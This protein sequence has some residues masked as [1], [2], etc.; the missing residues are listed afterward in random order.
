LPTA[1]D[2]APT[3]PSGAIL[4]DRDRRRVLRA[5]LGGIFATTFTITILGVSLR[6][7]ADDLGT[8]VAT[9]AWVM[10]GPMLAQALSLPVLG[11]MGDL[12]GHRRVYLIGFGVSALAAAATAFAWDA[13][14]LIGFRCLGQLAGTATMPASTALLFHAYP[15]R[16]RVRAMSYVSLVSAGAP[17][18]GLAIGGVLVD[19]IGWR[20]IFAIQ[21]VLGVAALLYAAMVLEESEH[22]GA[23]KLD[24][25]GA[26]TLAIAAFALTFAINRSP[27]WG[28]GHP[29]V[30]LAMAAIP[31]ALL[32]F[33]RIERKAESPLLPL[34]FFRERNFVS[35]LVVNF[36]M[37]FAYMGG[38]IISPLLLI[39]VFGFNATTTSLFVVCR[40]IAFA[41]A[42][43]VSGHIAMRF[44]EQRTAFIGCGLITASMIA[45]CFTAMLVD[46]STAA[47]LGALAF[48]L[49]VAGVGF[50]FIQPSIQA[51]VGNAVASTHFGIASSA[52]GM[53]GSVGAVAGIS[54]L[55]ALCADATGPMPYLH[56][57]ALATISSAIALAAAMMMKTR[58]V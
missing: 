49:V 24:R 48:G 29:S 33:V 8:D 45:F 35:P 30:L 41:F 32:L 25:L 37:N 55:T 9:I 57:Y 3:S 53:A 54:F 34:E 21:A 6:P 40:P 27:V 47:A 7:I 15:P 56:G 12:H 17:V 14:S 11:R 26:T 23:L 2:R 20:P 31:V 18:L 51:V 44:G 4:S 28:V 46:A 42:S 39:Q 36:A 19:E 52:L 13:A 16:E 1:S 22:G 50:G 5:C 38:F 43:P 58:R 10:T